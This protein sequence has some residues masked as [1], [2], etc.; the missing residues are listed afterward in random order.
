MGQP[1]TDERPFGPAPGPGARLGPY[2]LDARIGSG[3]I[4]AVYRGRGPEEELVAVKVLHPASLGT[5]EVKRFQREF[6]ALGRLEHPN[7]VSVRKAGIDGAYPWIAMEFIDGEDLDVLLARWEDEPPPDRWNRVERIL[8]DLCAALDHVHRH[9]LVHRDLKPGNVLVDRDGR[10]KLS[11]FGVVKDRSTDN[12]ALTMHGNLVGTVAFMAPE[13]I[14]SEEVD[15]RTDLYSLGAVL[16]VMLTGRRPIEATSVTGFLARHLAHVPPAPSSIRHDVPRRL[17]AVC[18]RLLYKDRGQR[19]PTAQAVLAALDDEAGPDAVP[20]RGRDRLLSAFRERIEALDAGEGAVVVVAGPEGSGRSFVLDAFAGLAKAAGCA[21]TR[22]SGRA[23]NPVTSLLAGLD[24]DVSTPPSSHLRGLAQAI[25]G[26]PTVLLVDDLDAASPRMTDALRRLTDK[27]VIEEGERLLLVGSTA[28]TQGPIETFL[29][30]GAQAWVL[31]PI[32]RKAVSAMLRDRGMRGPALATLTRRLH[33]ELAGR[34]GAVD[35][36]LQA[37]LQ[38]DWFATEEGRLVPRHAPEVLA[39]RPLPVPDR[40][41][42]EVQRRLSTL[43]PETLGQ[44]EALAVLDRPTSPRLLAELLQADELLDADRTAELVTPRET[45]AGTVLEISWP[46]AATVIRDALDPARRRALHAA[47]ATTLER[48]HRRTLAAEIA[49]HF[50]AAGQPGEAYP[51]YVRA[52][53]T[54]AQGKDH[55]AVLSLCARARGTRPSGEASLSPSKVMTL[56]RRLYQLEGEA[57]LARG[58]WEAAVDPL[59]EAV[60]AATN[61]G[62]AA[63]RA[64]ALGALGRAWY[65][66]GR[67]EEAAPYLDAALAVSE[68]GMPERVP[69]LRAAADLRLRE[70]KLAEAEILWTEA[71]HTARST[72]SKDA[73]A[74][75]RRGLGHLHTL[76]GRVAEASRQLEL[77]LDLIRSDEAPRVRAGL[78]SRA[79]QLDLAAG[80]T[81]SALH[82]AQALERLASARDLSDRLPQAR[83]L[84][85][86]AL[87]A[88]GRRDEAERAVEQAAVLLRAHKD[89]ELSLRLARLELDLGHPTGARQLLPDSDALA[90]DSLDDLP[91]ACA[92]VRARTLAGT[93]PD[94]A[95]DLA[96][97][98]LVRPPPRLVLRHAEI[99]LD[100][101]RALLQAGDPG[102]ARNAAKTGLRA[103][104]GPGLDGLRLELLRLFHAADPDPRV[105]EALV[106]V[107]RRLLAEQ[108]PE[109]ARLLLRGRGLDEYADATDEPSM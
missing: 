15:A 73:E 95:R 102:A 61:T 47:A 25:R 35:A 41:R 64:R 5:D 80:R 62:D 21:T 9:G 7:I 92:A 52:A 14:V 97:W 89:P 53:R 20:I 66:L 29:D 27:L 74:R 28:R 85:A 12:T 49:A 81:T 79:L 84:L 22:G 87:L 55:V 86:E 107:L 32:P 30:T 82:R 45:E 91:A 96:R 48:T 2:V 59:R 23:P 104:S 18:Q 60:E 50:D 83:V 33:T 26:R 76:Q 68:P 24:G 78:L 71:L 98:C 90:M 88:A 77:A 67:Y 63:A 8:R 58:A 103:L 99:L 69:A 19:F 40:A 57:H 10:A 65:R 38:Q 13:Q 94:R 16:Y 6:R 34:P 101:G 46:W 17:E 70:G 11:D 56:R 37:L 51:R 1:L 109:V 72:R 36:Q 108:P 100:A 105:R 39:R 93:R 31:G 3:G 4:A 75:A 42:I 43:S 106:S 44:V 54:A